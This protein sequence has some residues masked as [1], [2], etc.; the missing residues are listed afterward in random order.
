M[1][2]TTDQSQLT[3]KQIAEMAS[4]FVESD[5]GQY[6]LTQMNLHYNALHQASES[7]DLSLAHKAYKVERAAGLKFA[8]SWLTGKD[9]LLKSGYYDEKRGQEPEEESEE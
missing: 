2:T 1:T 3:P 8:I 6:Y 4:S 9:S 5:F 7:E